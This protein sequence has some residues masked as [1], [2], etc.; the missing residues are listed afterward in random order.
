MKSAQKSR[1]LEAHRAALARCRRCR[2]GSG[3]RPIV[4]RAMNPRVMLIGQAPGKVEAGIGKPFSGRA[5]QTLF[6]WR[7][8]AGIDEPAARDEIYISAISIRFPALHPTGPRDP[9][10]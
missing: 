9:A 5:G 4:S 3:I 6:R 2:L 10:P 7:E 1:A 8:R